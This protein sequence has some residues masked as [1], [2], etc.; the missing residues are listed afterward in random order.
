MKMK[1]PLFKYFS[2]EDHINQ[3]LSGSLRFMPLSYYRDIE[4]KNRRDSGE[5]KLKIDTPLITKSNGEIIQI[6]NST[7]ESQVSSANQIYTFCMSY[8]H[9]NDLFDRFSAK[10]CIEIPDAKAFCRIVT[11]SL[12]QEA[13]FLNKRVGH[14]VEYTNA[15]SPG[16]DWFFPGRLCTR[17]HP[18]FK[19]E[20]EFRLM[21]CTE[22]DG[23]KPGETTQS[24]IIENNPSETHVQPYQSNP[25]L[26]QVENL[27]G[28]CK[29]HCRKN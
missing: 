22:K 21:F 9:A 23:W 19:S 5:G 17:K 8:N 1:K 6:P 12:N 10:Y 24:I 14:K 4:D 27:K 15:P 7:F 18:R 25:I 26:L 28:F 16:I 3:F 2:E 29:V 11:C 13:E 20:K